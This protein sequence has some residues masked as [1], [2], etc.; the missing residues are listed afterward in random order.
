MTDNFGSSNEKEKDK[1]IDKQVIELDD[2]EQEA[3]KISQLDDLIEKHLSKGE[4]KVSRHG[5]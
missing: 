3:I 1:S 2:E 4:Q 5:L